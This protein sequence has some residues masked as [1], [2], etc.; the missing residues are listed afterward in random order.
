MTDEEFHRHKIALRERAYKNP[1]I[2]EEAR[3]VLNAIEQRRKIL[4][5]LKEAGKPTA[6]SSRRSETIGDTLPMT[7]PP[8]ST[9]TGGERV[10]SPP[11]RP[12]G[13]G[14]PPSTALSL[15]MGSSSTPAGST[16][17]L[18]PAMPVNHD[19]PLSLKLGLPDHDPQP[20]VSLKLATPGL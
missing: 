15:G 12:H 17:S 5:E 11:V 19:D 1:Q 8:A 7:T 6:S 20:D 10:M 9:S 13:T 2:R 18:K 4:K 3:E 16:L 14:V